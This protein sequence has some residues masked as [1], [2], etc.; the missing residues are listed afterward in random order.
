MRYSIC[1]LI[2]VCN[3]ITELIWWRSSL[4]HTSPRPYKG[5]SREIFIFNKP[6]SYSEAV[7]ASSAEA[8]NVIANLQDGT[9]WAKIMEVV[10]LVS[11]Y[12]VVREH[13]IYG[14]M[15]LERS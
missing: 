5:V 1:L 9:P 8:M 11:G 14:T 10:T 12:Q 13:F 3:T 6:A 15:H 4:S 2:Q 7:K